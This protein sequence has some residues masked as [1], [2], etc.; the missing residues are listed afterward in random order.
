MTLEHVKKMDAV[1]P[2]QEN[3]QFIYPECPQD[4]LE[5]VQHEMGDLFRHANHEHPMM[6]ELHRLCIERRIRQ[7]TRDS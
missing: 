2:R 3:E 1:T 7:L 5:R 4:I 6:R